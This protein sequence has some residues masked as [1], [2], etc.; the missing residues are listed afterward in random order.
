MKLLL[1]AGHGGR[2]PG[3]GT[4]LFNESEFTLAIVLELE[5]LALERHPEWTVALTRKSDIYLS[6]DAR[7]RM[8]MNLRPDLFISVHCN[9][10]ESGQAHGCEVVY[11]EDDDK[12]LA[13]AI[14]KNLI[15]DLSVR[16][17]G[18]IHDLN[19]L[20]RRLAVLSTPGIPSVIVEPGFITNDKDREML[21]RSTDVADA[22]LKGIEEWS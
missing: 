21:Q 13:E 8:C 12:K 2:D 9:G 20:K 5:R 16:D 17:R 1:D 4:G 6:P 11:R 19:D 18:I 7:R 15:S 10:A 22:I 3:A 14:Q